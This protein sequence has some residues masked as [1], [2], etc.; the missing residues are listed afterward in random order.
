MDGILVL[1]AIPLHLRPHR[2]RKPHRM[3]VALT[4]LHLAIKSFHSTKPIL[5]M[6]D[7]DV[8]M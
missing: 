4:I 5:K 2:T 7:R 1:P 6:A 3:Y 8:V